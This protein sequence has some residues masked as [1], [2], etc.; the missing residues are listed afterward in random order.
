MII[1]NG[2]LCPNVGAKGRAL[3]IASRGQRATE[4]DS[5]GLPDGTAGV[6][7]LFGHLDVGAQGPHTYSQR[8]HR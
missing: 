8:V 3:S 4:S 7:K 1:L 2:D 6:Y 5:R